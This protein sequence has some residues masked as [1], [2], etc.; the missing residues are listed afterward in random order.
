MLLPPGAVQT[1]G[2]TAAQRAAASE[3]NCSAVWV[4]T[5]RA[6]SITPN[7]NRQ[8]TGSRKAIS[9]AVAPP[10]SRHSEARRRRVAAA[11]VGD[12]VSTAFPLEPDAISG[13]RHFKMIDWAVS[14]IWFALHPLQLLVEVEQ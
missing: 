6:N 2:L 14:A 8:N 7:R 4:H 13:R 11:S 1:L 12:R 9:T 5:T 10:R 3:A